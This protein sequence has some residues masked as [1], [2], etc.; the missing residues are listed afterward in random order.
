MTGQHIIQVL[1]APMFET[2][3]VA[4]N[5]R[6]VL[7]ANRMAWAGLEGLLGDDDVAKWALKSMLHQY[8]PD[9]PNGSA[10]TTFTAEFARQPDEEEVA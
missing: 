3:T 6:D 5:A 10:C 2:M 9:G 1:N 8:N 7:D 4:G